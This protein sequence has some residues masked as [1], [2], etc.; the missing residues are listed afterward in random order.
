MPQ[1]QKDATTILSETGEHDMPSHVAGECWSYRAPQGFEQSRLIIGAIINFADRE[2]VFCCS[3]ADAPSRQ[4]D[5]GY[6]PATIPF[7]PL[8]QTAFEKSVV[9]RDGSAAPPAEFQ[10]LLSNWQNDDRGLSFF[11]VPFEGYLERMIAA[12]MADIVGTK[13]EDV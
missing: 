9:E 5:G 7:V 11:T 3:V 8:T 10:T 2:P 6:L 13:I 1:V 12:Q 4:D